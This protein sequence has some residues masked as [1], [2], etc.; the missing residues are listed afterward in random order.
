M[1]RYSEFCLI[2]PGS[3]EHVRGGKRVS[4]ELGRSCHL[5]GFFG[6]VWVAAFNNT[7]ALRCGASD[8]TGAKAPAQPWYRQAKEDQARREGWQEVL[9]FE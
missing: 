1:E 9:A 7:P 6:G 4:R 3:L 2:P 8:R 5:H